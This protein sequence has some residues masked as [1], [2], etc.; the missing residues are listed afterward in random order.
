MSVSP[1]CA[2]FACSVFMKVRRASDLMEFE[3]RGIMVREAHWILPSPKDLP[4]RP[5]P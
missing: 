1:T 2:P 3:L 4:S 5:H